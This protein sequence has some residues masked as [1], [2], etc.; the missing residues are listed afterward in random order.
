MIFVS[1]MVNGNLEEI[2]RGGEHKAA[3]KRKLSVFLFIIGTIVGMTLIG[4]SVYADFEASLFD[5]TIV[6]EGTI[7]PISC[8]V[9]MDVD[10]TGRVAAT[11]SNKSERVDEVVVQAHISRGHLLW[12]REVEN[13]L[14]L[15]PDEKQRLAWEVH[16]E[17]AAYGHLI[18]TKIIVLG[19]LSEPRNK[20]ACGVIVLDLPGNLRGGHLFWLLFSL[21]FVSTGYGMVLWWRYGRA[22]A[23]RRMEA[24]RAI[25]GLGV[26]ILIGLIGTATGFWELAAGCFYISVLLIGVIVPH[27][28]VVRN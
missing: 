7:R 6:S 15:V 2:N 12:F 16:S 4:V 10:E 5:I 26:L 14:S 17:D 20:G 3:Q 25:M 24:T 8:P 9:F 23:G 11:I 1:A 27:F 13:H 22:L 21:V 19:S 18:L 28:L